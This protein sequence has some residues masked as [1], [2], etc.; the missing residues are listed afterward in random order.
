MVSAISK[1]TS[2]GSSTSGSN[3][4]NSIGNINSPNNESS[5]Q[6]QQQQPN[7]NSFYSSS[8]TSSSNLIHNNQVDNTK[9]KKLINFNTLSDQYFNTNKKMVNLPYFY[10]FLKR[11]ID[12]GEK[13]KRDNQKKN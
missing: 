12:F 8:T 11:F 3:T 5:T 6:Q 1:R 2:G 13:K 4:S 7:S 10:H 9:Y